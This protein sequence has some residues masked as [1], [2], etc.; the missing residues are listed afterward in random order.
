MEYENKVYIDYSFVNY[1]IIELDFRLSS[2][3]NVCK[4]FYTYQSWF[5][6]IYNFTFSE[7]RV[8]KWLKFGYK[9]LNAY[10]K[11]YKHYF[12]VYTK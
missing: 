6:N 4:V 12:L 10:K 1:K 8:I 3:L 9:Q 7:Q 5:E 11:A 2:K